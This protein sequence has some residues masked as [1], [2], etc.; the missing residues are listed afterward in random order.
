MIGWA[1]QVSYPQ[2]DLQQVADK[3][4]H[5]DTVPIH[6][7]S[8]TVF[9]GRI[10]GMVDCR[11]ADLHKAPVGFDRIVL[12]RKYALSS[13]L[14]EISYDSGARVILQGPCTYQMESKN[15]GF[16]SFGRVT[17]KVEKS[18][19]GRGKREEG[20]RSSVN[21]QRLAISS[22]SPLSPLPTPLFFI[23]TPT[24]TVTDLGTE[25]GVEV[26]TSSAP[27]Q[28]HVSR[29]RSELRARRRQRPSG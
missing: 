9:V 19:E 14:M 7:E 11:W 29:A 2:S 20:Q 21:R 25:F 1:C 22:L 23:R 5:M 24:A 26:R 8:E 15:S 13:G 6:P 12:G 10:T 16:L 28:A 18:G 4:P 27:S 17:A 3:I